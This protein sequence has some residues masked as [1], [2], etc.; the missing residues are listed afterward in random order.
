MLTFKRVD[1]VESIAEVAGLALEIWQEYYVPIVGQ[2]QV[3]YMLEQFQSERAVAAQLAQ[4]FEYY[5]VCQ[6]RGNAGYFAVV[7]DA[8]KAALML[9]KIYVRKSERGHGLGKKILEFIEDLGQKRGIKMLWLTVNKNNADS[10]A[11]YSLMGFR[12]AGAVIQNIGGGFV[13]DDFRMEKTLAP[14]LVQA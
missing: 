6:N 11:W 4:S 12:N 9:S 8:E 14:N 10:I 2:K 3:D 5:L 13:M 7:P 1:S